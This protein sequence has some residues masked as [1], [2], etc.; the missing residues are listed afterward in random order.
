MNPRSLEGRR[1]AIVGVLQGNDP[2][3]EQWAVFPGTLHFVEERLWLKRAGAKPAVEIRPE[4]FDRIREVE[5]DLRDTLQGA[6][7]M[8]VLTVGALADD[9]GAGW[10][11]TGL[12]WPQS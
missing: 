2:D 4:W 12:R 9:E 7:Y 1:F 11:I 6:E 10:D 8:L 3:D 5:P